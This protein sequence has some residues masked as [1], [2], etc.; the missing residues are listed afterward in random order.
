MK[1]TVRSHHTPT[2]DRPWDGPATE[3]RLPNDAD[4]RKLRRV[5]AWTDPDNLE[6][7]TAAK[8]PHHEVSSNGRVGAANVRACINGISILNGGRGGADI[9]RKDREGVYRH[10]AVHL[11]DAGRKPTAL[12]K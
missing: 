3:T 4:A 7:E 1:A 6:S 2:I 9:P 11:E 12:N 8:F 5:F 10:L